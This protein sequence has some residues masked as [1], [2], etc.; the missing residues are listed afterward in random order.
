MIGDERIRSLMSHPV[1]KL[2]MNA[3][4]RDA[5]QFLR[6]WGISGAP[7][8]DLHGRPVGVFSLSDL[9]GHVTN[10]LLDMPTV[11]P[12]AERARETGEFI[13]TGRGFHFEGFDD[14]PVS[15]VMTPEIVCVEPDATLEEAVR[16]MEDLSIHRVFVRKG[17]GPLE[18]V[19]TTMDVLRSVGRALRS[20]RRIR[21]ARRVG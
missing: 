4:V 5:A 12:A 6:R 19:I 17:E 10:Q 20:R 15:D 14:V 9:A 16:V 21:K 18:G 1:R 7:V 8:L 13:P 11:D 3:K 2:T